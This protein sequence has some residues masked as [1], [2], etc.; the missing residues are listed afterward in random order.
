[1][2]FADGKLLATASA[3]TITEGRGKYL[4]LYCRA[5]EKNIFLDFPVYEWIDNYPH[6]DGEYDRWDTK[7]L[8]I[9]TL[10]FDYI[11]RKVL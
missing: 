10:T 11:N 3:P 7:E 4:S 2:S 1:M 9:N 6:C 5:D 8:D